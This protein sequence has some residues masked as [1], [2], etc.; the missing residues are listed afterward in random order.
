MCIR[1]RLSSFTDE[2][3]HFLEADQDADREALADLIFRLRAVDPVQA[4][5]SLLHD[6]RLGKYPVLHGRSFRLTVGVG[7][8]PGHSIEL[9]GYDDEHAPPARRRPR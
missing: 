6:L 1:D 3:E 4:L 5:D 2:H 7:T 9:L 8:W